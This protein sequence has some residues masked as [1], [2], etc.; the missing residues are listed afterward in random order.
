MK[1]HLHRSIALSLTPAIL[2]FSVFFLLP[3][4]VVIYTSFFNWSLAELTF[5][6]FENYREMVQERAFQKAVRNNLIWSAAVVF[7][8]IPLATFVAILLSEKMRGWRVFRTVFFI[9]NMISWAALSLIFRNVIY[10]PQ[11][12]LL[13]SVLEGI[14][15]ESWTRPWLVDLNFALPAVIMSWMFNIGLW[16]VIIMAEIAAIPNGLYEAAQ[17]DGANKLQ[18]GRFITLPLLKNVIGTCMILSVSLGLVSFE[19]IFLMTAGGPANETMNLAMHL[20]NKF[21]FTQFGYAN[22]IAVFLIILG[23]VLML[24]INRVF[25]VGERI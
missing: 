3:L 7:I 1:R 8:H 20:Y 23:F 18:Q 25:R 14:G 2:L 21:T 19:L 16:M 15:L 5:T 12:G 11:W 10:N 6:G 9:P 24:V 4:A 22:S 17:I 13:N